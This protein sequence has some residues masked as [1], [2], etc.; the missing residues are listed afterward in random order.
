M[1]PAVCLKPGAESERMMV[2][3]GR[4]EE[5]EEGGGGGG[6]TKEVNASLRNLF[7]A[8]TPHA[9]QAEPIL[10]AA[11]AEGETNEDDVK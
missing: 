2:R 8:D 6:E 10:V 11:I 5:E 7:R 1:L 3:G 9:P 4:T